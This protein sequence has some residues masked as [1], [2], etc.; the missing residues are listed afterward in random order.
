M[1]RSNTPVC[2]SVAAASKG[3]VSFVSFLH[4]PP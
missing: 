4:L 2:G 3:F 1:T